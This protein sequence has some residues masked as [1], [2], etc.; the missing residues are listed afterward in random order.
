MDFFRIFR[1]KNY[2]H[3]EQNEIFFYNPE[4]TILTDV[5]G[6]S[7]DDFIKACFKLGEVLY[8]VS[9]TTSETSL[10]IKRMSQHIIKKIYEK[11]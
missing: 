9:G 7:V 10:T 1:K 2:K 8:E 6:F 5:G 3:K 11:D 4:E